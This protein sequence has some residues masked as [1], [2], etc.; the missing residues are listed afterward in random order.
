MSLEEVNYLISILEKN[1]HFKKMLDSNDSELK[2]IYEIATNY[3][4]AYLQSVNNIKGIGGMKTN[5]DNNQDLAKVV[6]DFYNFL[7]IPNNILDI[8]YHNIFIN[9]NQERARFSNGKIYLG[10][11]DGTFDYIKTVVHEVAHSIRYYSQKK[12]TYTGLIAEVESKAVENI[13]YK[14]LIE[15]DIKI[16]KTSNNELRSLTYEDVRKQ[17]LHEIENEKT[18]IKRTLEEYE[19]IKV[20]KENLNDHGSYQFT[21]TSFDK[22]VNIYGAEKINNMKFLKNNYFSSDPFVYVEGYDL[23][24]GRHI[25]NEFRFVYARLI[26]EY[27]DNTAYQD[28]FGEYLLS[29]DIKTPEDVMSYFKINNLDDLVTNQINK[30]NLESQ[31]QLTPEI[32]KN[33]NASKI[34]TDIFDQRSQSEIQMDSS[35]KD[36]LKRNDFEN[37]IIESLQKLK[38][39][40]KLSTRQMLELYSNDSKY[41]GIVETF[42]KQKMELLQQVKQDRKQ[43]AP[44][45]VEYLKKSFPTL[46]DQTISKLADEQFYRMSISKFLK[47]VISQVEKEYGTIIPEDKMAKLKGLADFK[48]IKLNFN[49]TNAEADSKNGQLI[50]NPNETLGNT[51]E[52]KIVM[53]MGGS[54]HE[55]FHLL[56]NMN[57]SQEQAMEDSERLKY[58]VSTSEGDKEVHFAPGKYGQVLN[59]GFVEKMSSEFAQRNG[60]YC[61]IN[62][63]YIPYVEVCSKIMEH[64]N[65][66]TPQVLFTKNVDAI[67]EKMNPDIRTKYEEAERIAVINHFSVREAIND[68]SLKNITS[69]NVKESWMEKKGVDLPKTKN[70]MFKGTLEIKREEKKETNNFEVHQPQEKKSEKMTTAI[71]VKKGPEAES[72]SFTRRS[73]SE[74]QIANQIKQ[75][76]TIKHNENIAKKTM[77]KPKTLV[78]KQNTSSNSSSSGF[79]DALILTLITGFV[80][81]AIFMIVYNILK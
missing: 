24:N 34:D 16:I 43:M 27:I 58:I 68:S 53:S 36:S 22:A 76:N 57:K 6:K 23:E 48:N 20:L 37:D 70:D 41:S 18:F 26:T 77:D 80:V 3:D 19:L 52:E 7:Q 81:G 47:P 51:V 69:D 74:I 46:P 38:Q 11:N 12:A 63:R 56:I 50:F 30:Y 54:I 59:E 1:K 40:S 61:M 29:S 78:K 33:S 15:K 35:Q 28:N 8:V 45:I 55:A 71:S 21:Q 65:S 66:I 4:K 13:F 49:G 31:I 5:F 17:K 42:Q 39:L 32:E 72:V 75:K 62:P 14:Y 67:R 64:D 2:M 79:V 9:P 10:L 73:E 25:S 44:R 60:F